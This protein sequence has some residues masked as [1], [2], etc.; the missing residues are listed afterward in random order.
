[1][2]Y[3]ENCTTIDSLK[4]NEIIQIIEFYQNN[5]KKG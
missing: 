4:E 5:I 1:M 2:N 3:F